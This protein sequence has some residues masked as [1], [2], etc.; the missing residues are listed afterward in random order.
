[1]NQIPALRLFFFEILGSSG[2]GLVNLAEKIGMNQQLL[3]SRTLRGAGQAF[4]PCL[5]LMLSPAVVTAT[6][7]LDG[8]GASEFWNLLYPGVLPNEEDSDLDGQSNRSEMIAGTSPIDPNDSFVIGSVEFKESQVELAWEGVPGKCYQ[9][10]SLNP[11]SSE[12]ATLLTMEPVSSVQTFLRT[13]PVV[14][15]SGI[16]RVTSRDVDFDGDGVNAWEEYLMGWNDESWSSSGTDGPDFEEALRE[17]ESADG[18]T[19]ATGQVLAQRLPGEAEAARF[20]VQTSFGPTMES[21]QAVSEKGLTAYLDEQFSLIPSLSR[22]GM[23]RTGMPYSVG[24][25]RHGWWRTALVAP[26]QLRQRMAYALSQ[27]FVVNTEPGTVI[28][29]NIN[30]QATY[31]DIFV[32]KGFESF[33]EVLNDVTYSPAMGFYL[34][35]LNNRKGDPAMNRF[36]DENFAREIMQLF[37]IGL[38]KLNSD[39]SLQFDE[40]GKSIPTYDNA[41][42]TELA[43]VFTGMSNSTTDNGKIAT[44]FFDYPGGGDYVKPMKVWEEEHEQGAKTLFDNVLIPDG[45]TGE[46][47]VQQALDALCAHENVAPFIC[48][49][50]IQR[51]TTSNPSA[52]YLSR[53]TASW[54]TSEGDLG[55]VFKAI[56]LDPEARAGGDVSSR[57]GKVREPLLRLTHIM[58]AFAEPNPT[59]G[60]Y[61]VSANTLKNELGQYVMSSPTVFNFYLPGHSPRGELREMGLVSPELQIATTSSLLA[62]HDRLKTTATIGHS[63]R[64]IDY[65]DELPLADD[66]EELADR[67]NILLTWGKM[68]TMLREVVIERLQNETSQLEKVRAAV[69]VIVTSPEYSVLK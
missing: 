48:Y 19:L 55:Q 5:L 9:I 6:V 36:P 35:H 63:V 60:N 58:R 45:Q 39:G 20:L 22:V 15:Q 41:V 54:N 27:V 37:T 29:D 21:I 67:L 65:T 68:S 16:Y 2:F 10:Q 64:G 57:S 4:F 66:P 43:K 44:S 3:F 61:G 18:V 69:Q 28:G 13:I 26:D 34:S 12:W 49:R 59:V 14:D 8:D 1:M 33:R 42:I 30:T 53:V 24:L 11:E 56:L 51:F 23:W 7:D 32:E 38:W 40:G 25:W 50:L 17:L 52:A 62:T 47:D 31:Y 46:E